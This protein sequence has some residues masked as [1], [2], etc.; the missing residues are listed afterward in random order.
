[1][2]E[3]RPAVDRES[4]LGRRAATRVVRDGVV[5]VSSHPANDPPDRSASSS[6]TSRSIGH[7]AAIAIAVVVVQSPISATIVSSAA[8]SPRS[9]IQPG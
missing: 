2:W 1:M 4:I 3:D 6:T 9:R 7:A 5:G 8:L